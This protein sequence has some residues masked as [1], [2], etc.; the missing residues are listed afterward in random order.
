MMETNGIASKYEPLSI[1]RWHRFVCKQVSIAPLVT[2]RIV[3]GL[4]MLGSILRFWW[5]G[6]VTAV[7]ILPKFHFTYPG[8]SWVHPLPGDAMHWVFAVMVLATVF[9]TLGLAYRFASIVFFVLFTYVEL[10]DVTTYLNH[11]YFISLVSFLLIWLPA[12]RKSSLDVKLGWV[13]EVDTVPLWTIGIIRFQM[14]VVYV[15][16]GIAKLNEDW[17]INALPMKIWL[18]AKSHLPIV[19][20]WMYEEWVAYLFSWFGAVY[21]LFIAFFLLNRKTRPIAYFFVIT[22]HIAT[23]IFFPGIGMFPYVM[24]VCGLIFFSST[25]HERLLSRVIGFKQNITAVALQYRFTSIYLSAL[26]LYVAVQ[27]VM[28]FRYLFYPKGLFWHEEGFRF[29]WRVMLMEKSGAA[30]F[31]IKE[32]ST[33]RSFEVNN[34]VWLTPLQEK[35]MSTQPD[36]I[37]QYAHYLASEYVKIGVKEPEVYGDIYVSLNGARS[38]QFIDTS[39][40]LS[41]QHFSWG[42]YTWV[43]PYK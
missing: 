35:M 11:Y 38:R 31:T 34:R 2:Y 5:R 14:A 29:S 8:F 27:L 22:F 23:A 19:G 42:H 33:N 9:I 13:R 10:L 6:W 20:E 37:L 7:Y 41:M 18:P 28:P 17:L 32:K 25:F 26:G 43:L 36:L 30:Y 40:E 24:V 21:D 12:G 3:F 16:A 4:L 1:S 39:I 15:F